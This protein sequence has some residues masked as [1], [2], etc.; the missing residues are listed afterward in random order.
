MF[1]FGILR[2]VHCRFTSDGIGYKA[3]TV[4][5]SNEVRLDKQIMLK[6]EFTVYICRQSFHIWTVF[7]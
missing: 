4:T 3:P 2:I 1:E 7:G 6:R 5:A